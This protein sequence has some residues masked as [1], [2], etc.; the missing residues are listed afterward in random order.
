MHLTETL[1]SVCCMT[2]H[3]GKYI[4]YLRV[5]T[6]KQGQSG[7]GL[8]A[9]RAA[10][11][12]WL[13]GGN[14]ELVEEVV[15][16][17][18]GK[19]HRNRP[20]LTKALAACRR[21]GAQ[22]IISRLDRLSRDPVFLLSLRDAGIDFV[23]VD[24]PNANR[25]TIGIMAMVAE[26]EREAISIR[27]RAALQAARARGVRLGNP[28]PETA[29]FHD[30]AAASAAGAKG[31]KTR[32]TAA[33]DF[34]RLIRPL[35]DS[36]LAGLSAHAAAIELNRRGVQTARGN[37]KWTARSVLNLKARKVERTPETPANAGELAEK[38]LS[39]P[40]LTRLNIAPNLAH[41]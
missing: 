10:V 36:E 29:T 40:P 2:P 21:Y 28:R 22:L 34:A 1:V 7:L 19:N 41:R 17:E 30:R 27:T 9:Q 15:E 37:G 33:N 14:W 38:Q 18:S 11:G 23:A 32:V 26:Q 4:S 31:S 5:S 24:M 35:F 39:H 12:N 8:E 3:N 25:L 20:G 13:N 6:A 16:V